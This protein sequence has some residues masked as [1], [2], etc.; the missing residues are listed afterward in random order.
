MRPRNGA[1]SRTST[2]R[3]NNARCSRRA[4]MRC[5]RGGDDGG[6]FGGGGDAGGCLCAEAGSCCAVY[7]CNATADAVAGA[8]FAD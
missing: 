3:N 8:V 7:G 1:H 4:T 6:C 2:G 5:R